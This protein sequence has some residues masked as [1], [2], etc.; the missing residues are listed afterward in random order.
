MDRC[1]SWLRSQIFQVSQSVIILTVCFGQKGPFSLQSQPETMKNDTTSS[2]WPKSARSQLNVSAIRELPFCFGF[3]AFFPILKKS[4]QFGTSYQSK[5][6]DLHNVIYSQGQKV[7]KAKQ[8]PTLPLSLI[9]ERGRVGA[10]Y[11]LLTF[12]PC[13]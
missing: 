4:R 1:H 12:S 5:I 13:E 11:A 2:H 10:C 6:G 7:K 8:A 9:R 3:A